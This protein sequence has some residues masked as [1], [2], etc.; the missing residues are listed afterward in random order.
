MHSFFFI[1]NAIRIP[2]ADQKLIEYL[3][4]LHEVHRIEF[5]SPYQLIRP[6]DPVF[7]TLETRSP[8]AIEWGILRIK[9]DSVWAL[10]F[11][12]QGITVG[13][14]DTGVE[15]HP[16]IKNNYR[17]FGATLDHNYNWHDAIHVLNPLNKDANQNEY[18]N[19]CGLD[20]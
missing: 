15:L 12:G 19:P 18:N 9:A 1:V 13:S 4:I 10:G 20:T 11:R 17:G 3:S 5:N 6:V 16:A 7:M 8:L 14:E 2:Q